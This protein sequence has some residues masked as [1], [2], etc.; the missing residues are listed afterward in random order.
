MKDVLFIQFY[1][2]TG[3]GWFDLCNGF[4]DTWDLCRSKGDFLWIGILAAVV[5]FIVSPWTNPIFIKATSSHPYIGGYIKFFILAT[6]G[7]LL[8]I[9]IREKNWRKPL[10][11][12]Y[13]AILWGFFGMLITLIFQLFAGGVVACLSKGYLPGRNSKLAFAFFTATLMNIFYAPVFMGIHKCTDTYIDLKCG[14]TNPSFND[15]LEAADWNTFVNFVLLKTIPFF[16]IPAHTIT[17]LLPGEY[18][19]I[20]AAF[21]SIALGALLAFAKR[22]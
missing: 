4:S 2:Q 20:V 3:S 16:W 1:G 19:I 12:I 14:G 17:F 22:K 10:G 9:R 5:F 18:R 11:V 13:R 6:M 21:L 8:A 7:E 15:V